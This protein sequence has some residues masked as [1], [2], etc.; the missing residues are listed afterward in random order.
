MVVWCLALGRWVCIGHGLSNATNHDGDR[1]DE[2]T[3]PVFHGLRMERPDVLCGSH[4][5]EVVPNVRTPLPR[6]PKGHVTGGR[7]LVFRFEFQPEGS[8]FRWK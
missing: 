7:R 4:R 1:D 2:F 5:G 6:V 8:S 3:D